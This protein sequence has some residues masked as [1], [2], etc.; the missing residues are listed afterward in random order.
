M[1]MAREICRS[2]AGVLAGNFDFE[3]DSESNDGQR[4]M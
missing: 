3:G 2:H 1:A 4:N